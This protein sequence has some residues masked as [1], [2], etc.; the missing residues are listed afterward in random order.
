MSETEQPGQSA[1]ATKRILQAAHSGVG[2]LRAIAEGVPRRI[3]WWPIPLQPTAIVS[4]P[5]LFAT[6]SGVPENHI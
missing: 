4:A 6:A 1:P 3:G 2:T 5:C